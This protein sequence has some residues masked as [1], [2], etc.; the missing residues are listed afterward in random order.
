MAN[1]VFSKGE[2]L[3]H[4]TWG[5]DCHGWTFLDT[6]TVSVK[7]E[8]MPP[9]TA[10]QLH[11]HEHAIQV[12]F[13]LKGRATFSIDGVI[14]ELREQQGIEIKPQ[15]KHFIANHNTTDLEFILYSYPSTKND[16]IE[17]K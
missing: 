13:I 17:I 9:D 4:Y 6:E 7:Q 15:Q 1:K 14:T 10:E 16:R 8:L 2:C 11:Y 12:F 5:D 3:D